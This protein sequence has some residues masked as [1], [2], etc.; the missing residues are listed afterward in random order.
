[1]ERKIK[2]AL[3]IQVAVILI[4]PGL[5]IML[6]N[7]SIF[8]DNNNKDIDFTSRRLLNVKDQSARDDSELKIRIE[9]MNQ[10]WDSNKTDEMAMKGDSTC[11]K[12]P[13]DLSKIARVLIYALAS[14]YFFWM[15]AIVSDDYLIGSI[16]ILCQKFNIKQDVASATIM[17]MATSAPE[18]FISCVGTFITEGDIGIETVVGSAVFN[19]LAVPAFCGLVTRTE[20]QLEWW[21]ISRD[22]IFYGLSVIVFIAVIYDNQIM[23]YEAACLVLAYA[24]Y[25]IIMYKNDLMAEKVMVLTQKFRHRLIRQSYHE[26]A[27]IAPLFSQKKST[28]ASMDGFVVNV[29]ELSEPFVKVDE[30]DND[31]DYATSPWKVPTTDNTTIYYL[32]WPI[33]FTLWCTIPDS[34]RFKNCYLLTFF[35]SALWICCISYIIV[36]ITNDVDNAIG[37]T[38]MAAGTSLP[39]VFSSI[40]VTRQGYSSMGITNPLGSN[41]FDILLCLG[42]PWLVK[43]LFIPTKTGQRW[44]MLKSTGISYT[45]ISLLS[46]LGMLLL[47]LVFNRFKLD[48]RVGIYCLISY[49]TFF[50]F[51]SIFETNLLFLI[52]VRS[53]S[54]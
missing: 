40:I 9:P 11:D 53:C 35:C 38:F 26:I 32:K 25:L 29:K 39:E 43:T 37:L 33:T 48:R 28:I 3:F 17:A 36:F 16:A 7:V 46:T 8:I 30:S 50:C 23:W 21:P 1:M 51:V 10:K 52:N 27:E 6:T 20:T 19:V 24:I 34:R 22:C 42:L 14:C 44:I 41:I 47:L 5:Y 18:L 4:G 31:C 45:M 12:F 15:L 2:I 49:I 13:R 54:S